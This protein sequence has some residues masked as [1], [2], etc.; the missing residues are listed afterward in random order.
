MRKH[1]INYHEKIDIIE[2]ISKFCTHSKKI[3]TKTTNKKKKISFEKE[4]FL[5]QSNYV[6]FNIFTKN[7]KNFLIVIK[8]LFRKKINFD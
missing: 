3:K 5:Y 2:F 8:I 1:E 4:S 6:K 7:L